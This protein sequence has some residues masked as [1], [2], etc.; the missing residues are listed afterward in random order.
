M[1]SETDI[2]PQGVL[3]EGR[4]TSL[5]PGLPLTPKA[6]ETIEPAEPLWALTEVVKAMRNTEA[7]KDLKSISITNGEKYVGWQRGQQKIDC[8]ERV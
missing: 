3:S 2:S 8:V 7:V 5:A 6:G 1:F 4:R